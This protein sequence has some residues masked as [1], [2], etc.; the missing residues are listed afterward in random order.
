MSGVRR[1]YN[2]RPVTRFLQVN[3]RRIHVEED[4]HHLKG[5]VRVLEVIDEC[6]AILRVQKDV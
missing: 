2:D 1:H 5:A 6:L 3:R 4:D